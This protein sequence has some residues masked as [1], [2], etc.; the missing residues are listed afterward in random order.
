MQPC[1]TPMLGFSAKLPIS[2]ED[3][4]WTDEGFRRLERLVGRRRMLEAKV[5]LPTAGDFPDPYDKAALAAER[6]FHRVCAYMQVSGGRVQLE[7]F[8]DETEELREI[9][10]YWHGDEGQRAAGI[11]LNHGNDS[12]RSEEGKPMVVA[13]R[14]T[15]L[16]D[17]LALVATM[18]HEL[19]HVILLGGGLL[20]PTT[21]SDHEPMTDLLT[22]F[23]GLGIF[24]ANSA[25]RFK[26][27]QDE[28]R[29]GWS[30]Q[31][32][33]YIPEQVHG[34]ALAKFAMERGEGKPDWAKHLSTNVRSYFKQSRRWLQQNTPA[35][36]RAASGQ[37][38]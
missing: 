22:V 17:P 33:G 36:E 10:P 32:L 29:Q 11:Y 9:L 28:R 35:F 19:G 4:Q 16:K 30:M 27:Y 26:Q 3:R 8:D 12:N 6:L 13:I 1:R 7:I 15:Q 34:Y 24:T 18:A 5:V 20:N 2:D 38:S 14:S 31:R 37:S 25:A 23:L 21:T